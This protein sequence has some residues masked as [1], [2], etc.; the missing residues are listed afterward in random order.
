MREIDLSNLDTAIA[1]G[2]AVCDEMGICCQERG[3]VIFRVLKKL[4][5]LKPE[6]ETAGTP[7]ATGP[8]GVSNPS[9]TPTTELP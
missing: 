8:Q 3:R 4:A 9:P 6:H 5:E 7:D 2:D 1:L